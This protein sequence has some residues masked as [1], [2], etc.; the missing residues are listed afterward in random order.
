MNGDP[1]PELI[2]I[3]S[4]LLER[5]VRLT[6]NFFDL[7]ADSLDTVELLQLIHNT[8]KVELDPSSIIYALDLNDISKTISLA[9][10][11]KP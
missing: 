7:G 10:E 2:K 6:D 1:S 9:L 11:S 3:I 4:D 8:W 5:P